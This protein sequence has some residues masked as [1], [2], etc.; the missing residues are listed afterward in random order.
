MTHLL[1]KRIADDGGGGGGEAEGERGGREVK[2][3]EEKLKKS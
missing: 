3:Q 2:R 1:P